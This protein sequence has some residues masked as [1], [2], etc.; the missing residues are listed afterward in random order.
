MDANSAR[1]K[2]LVVLYPDG[3]IEVFGDDRV[4]ARVVNMPSVPVRGEAIAEDYIGFIL[5]KPYRD[6][7]WPGM[8]RATGN[9]ARITPHDITHQQRC[10]GLLRACD[11][12]M[13]T[14]VVE[15]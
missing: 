4:D 5:P 1:S 12:L 3:F 10:L 8:S 2:V 15:L 14:E 6:V 9:V 11:R 7:Y 13:T